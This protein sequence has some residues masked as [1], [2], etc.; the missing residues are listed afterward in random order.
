MVLKKNTWPIGNGFW[1]PVSHHK[2]GVIP[3][4]AGI[5]VL[6]TSR[7][8]RFRGNDAVEEEGNLL[9]RQ[10]LHRIKP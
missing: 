3:A 4:K 8:S 5:S 10:R 9:P 1:R 2:L 6:R 7:D